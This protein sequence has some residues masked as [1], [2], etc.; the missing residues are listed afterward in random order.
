MMGV[1]VIRFAGRR[2]HT[3]SHSSII[4]LGTLKNNNG[5]YVFFLFR[6]AV[7]RGM[8]G[9]RMASAAATTTTTPNG[10]NC[11]IVIATTPKADMHAVRTSRMMDGNDEGRGGM[12]E[13]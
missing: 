6:K 3:H 1:H 7:A 13:S 5:V 2:A 4:P 11:I 10:N 8:R 12:M 9:G